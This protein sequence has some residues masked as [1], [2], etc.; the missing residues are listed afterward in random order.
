VRAKSTDYVSNASGNDLI[1]NT[2]YHHDNAIRVHNLTKTYGKDVLALAG[3]SLSVRKGEIFG[4]LGPNGA[5]KST[6]VK[7]LT[8]L[9]LP[10]SGQAEVMGVDVA[11]GPESVRRIIGVVA[12]KSGSDPAATGRE[13]LT[14]QGEL[15]S[16]DGQ[17]LE[18]RVQELLARFGLSEVADRPAK[19]YSGGMIRRLDIAMGLIHHPTVLFLDEPT[20][21]LDPESRAEMWQDVEQLARD[22]GVTI[23]LTTHYLEE[24]DRLADRVAIIDRGQIVVEGTPE[25]LKAELEGDALHVEL[26]NGTPVDIARQALAGLNGLGEIMVEDR[27][28]HARVANGRTVIS[29]VFSTLDSAGVPVA[30]VTMSRPSL[31]DVYLRYAGRSFRAAETAQEEDN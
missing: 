27:I 23:F 13:N 3:I 17:A 20:T 18:R 7:I 12:Q 28:L 15:H 8:T 2:S 9:S 5:G 21:G 10:D 25:Q 26:A 6:T 19:T 30:A 1:M 14:L 24:A 22:E 31:D 29:T 11:L 16:I 4:L